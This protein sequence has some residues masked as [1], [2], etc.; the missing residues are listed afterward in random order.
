MMELQLFQD[1]L[2]DLINESDALNVTE[3]H[4]FSNENRMEAE[5]EDGSRIE[6]VCQPVRPD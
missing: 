6:I 1:I 3:L 4:T 5:W 2:F